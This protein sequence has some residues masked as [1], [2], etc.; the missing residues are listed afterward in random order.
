MARPVHGARLWHAS[1]LDLLDQST[2]EPSSEIGR[3]GLG[4]L[5]QAVTDILVRKTRS[6]AKPILSHPVHRDLKPIFALETCPLCHIVNLLST[7]LHGQVN[8]INFLD[9]VTPL[10]QGILRSKGDFMGM[11]LLPFAE[12]KGP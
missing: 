2:F 7:Q 8:L 1:L 11:V 3:T 6:H 9:H 4:I 5:A 10:S 12:Q